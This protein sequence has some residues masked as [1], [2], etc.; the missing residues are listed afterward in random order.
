M[1]THRL[2]LIACFLTG[3]ISADTI[4]LKSGMKYDGKILSEN[5]K[6]YLIEIRYSASIKDERRIPKEDVKTITAD[7]EDAKD[8]ATIKAFLPTPDMLSSKGYLK[9]I[10]LTSSFLKKYPELSRIRIEEVKKILT[11]LENEHGVIAKGGFKLK[12]HLISATQ[13]QKNAYDI[14]AS[15]LFHK[16][17]K[18][19]HS[20][21][22]PLALRTWEDLQ[23]NFSCSLAYQESL[24][25]VSRILKAHKAELDINL[26]SLES[27]LE[28][29]AAAIKSL[30][31]HDKSRAIQTIAEKDE[32]Y[33][34]L[35]NKEEKELKSKWLTI[36]P[37]N[38]RA[39]D[40]N[41]RNTEAAYNSISTMDTSKLE[42]AAPQIGS[43]LSALN[44]GNIAE[45]QAGIQKLTSMK[46]QTKYIEPLTLQLEEK[47][48]AILK[49][50]EAAEN[51]EREAVLKAEADKKAAEE[52]GKKTEED[53]KAARKKARRS[54]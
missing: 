37:F 18:I 4:E 44:N 41:L 48:L 34:A 45:A 10:E 21:N 1:K 39:L 14:D 32:L 26:N 17:K 2:L 31:K 28:R 29:R 8:Y 6:T 13:V 38:K 33:E 27:R 30:E 51:R 3:T 7:S 53:A 43:T 50:K 25:I 40:Y 5:E 35:I 15:I 11:T 12:G 16:L 19:A 42:L 49:E 52:A 9:R 36:D 23:S 54:R 24:P 47:K 46:L 22:Y 20:G